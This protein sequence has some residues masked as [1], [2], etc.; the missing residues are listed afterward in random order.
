MS[1]NLIARSNFSQEKK[2]IRHCEERNTRRR[3]PG[4]VYSVRGHPGS[5]RRLTP[6]RDDGKE[7]ATRHWAHGVH[8]LFIHLANPLPLPTTP[9]VPSPGGWE[10]EWAGE[11][12][13]HWA[14]GVHPNW[15]SNLPTRVRCEGTLRPH[16]AL[17]TSQ[18]AAPKMP[19][20]LIRQ[21]YITL[22]TSWRG[23]AGH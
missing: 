5:P 4:A 12:T 15:R 6:A 11:V 3:N 9:R 20:H 16:S 21:A 1:S 2:N 23:R 8:P 7:K 17:F 14:H 10:G 22:P 13:K 18:R 19:P